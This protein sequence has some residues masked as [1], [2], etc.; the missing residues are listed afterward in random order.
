MAL[1]SSSVKHKSSETT[2]L[3]SL[4]A[5]NPETYT[6]SHTIELGSAPDHSEDI[7]QVI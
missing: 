5:I 2:L 1:L 6:V 7:L 3:G 4:E